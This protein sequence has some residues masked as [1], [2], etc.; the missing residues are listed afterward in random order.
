MKNKNKKNKKKKE[1]Q[2][3]DDD[4]EDDDDDYLFYS[5]FLSSHLYIHMYSPPL[6][7]HKLSAQDNYRCCCFHIHLSLLQ[8]SYKY[9]IHYIHNACG[10]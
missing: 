3:D 10:W 4:D 2:D 7:Q 1:E 8:K 6:H 5:L 9:Q